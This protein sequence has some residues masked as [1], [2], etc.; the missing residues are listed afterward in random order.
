MEA[1][2]HLKRGI[3]HYEDGDYDGAITE[4]TKAIESDSKCVPA[5][6]NRELVRR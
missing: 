2:E 4:Y 5:W 1:E 6:C 3:Q